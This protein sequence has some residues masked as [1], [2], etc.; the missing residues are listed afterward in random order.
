MQSIPFQ[1]YFSR[2][3]G[4]TFHVQSGP[5]QRIEARLRSVERHSAMNTRFECFSLVFQLPEDIAL[6]QALYSVTDRDGRTC[7]LLLAPMKA[8]ASVSRRWFTGK[9]QRSTP[10]EFVGWN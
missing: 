8:D 10:N 3:E 6:P 4:A 2:A 1:E 7:D 5:E 9:R